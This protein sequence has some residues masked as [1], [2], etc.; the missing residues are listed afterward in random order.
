VAMSTFTV[1]VQNQYPTHRLGEVSAGLQFF[2]TLGATIGLAVLG[3]VLNSHFASS[4]ATSLPPELQTLATDPATA[5]QIN[6]PQALLSAPAQAQLHSLFGQFG[7]KSEAVYEAF[8]A[9]VRH[10]LQSALGSLFFLTMFIL[11]AG[12]IVVLFLKEVPL[13]RTHSEMLDSE[14]PAL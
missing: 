7:D 2:R 1:I 3:T 6:N 4:L 9:A 8:M 11:A 13:R 14:P 5:S 12:F 10:S